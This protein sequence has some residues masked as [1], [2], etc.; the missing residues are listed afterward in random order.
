MCTGNS[1]SG[2]K[3]RKLHVATLNIST[4]L[5][6]T[7]IEAVLLHIYKSSLIYFGLS[8]LN[9]IPF[10]YNILKKDYR[11]KFKPT[12]GL[13][14]V[15]GA[16]LLLTSLTNENYNGAAFTL[17][18]LFG[19]FVIGDSGCFFDTELPSVD[20]FQYLQCFLNF[21]IISALCD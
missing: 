5:S 20:A 19:Y 8:C 13:I 15:N 6:F 11:T 21:F 9:I 7:I 1:E 18:Y 12:D 3:L 17:S 14:A 2:Y 16:I 10:M 4:I